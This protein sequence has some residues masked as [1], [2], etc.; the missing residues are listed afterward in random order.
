MKIVGWDYISF[1][2]IILS[3]YTCLC[4]CCVCAFSFG[5]FFWYEYMYVC[6]Y[7]LLSTFQVEVSLQ[8][9]PHWS[10]FLA[11]TI[12]FTP[13]PTVNRAGYHFRNDSV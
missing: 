10:S 1:L 8:D 11:F 9:S 12:Y 13:H 4:V 7:V 2:F 6:L 3:L 5:V